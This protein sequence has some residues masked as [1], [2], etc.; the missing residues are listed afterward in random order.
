[1]VLRQGN[2]KGKIKNGVIVLASRV[3]LLGVPRPF[4]HEYVCLV[5]WIRTKMQNWI[6]DERQMDA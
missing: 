3:V 4:L 6:T 5:I 1:M 2:V